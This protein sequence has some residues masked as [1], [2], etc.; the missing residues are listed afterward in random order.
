MLVVLA[1][2]IGWITTIADFKAS[3]EEMP[4]RRAEAKSAIRSIYQMR[5]QDGEWP[6]EVSVIPSGVPN[7]WSYEYYSPEDA[8]GLA[9]FGPYHL[10]L[11]YR[12][13]TAGNREIDGEWWFR[14][15]GSPIALETESDRTP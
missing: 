4:R 13:S 8:P 9:L 15:E 2:V 10:V 1:M 7:G 6:T 3:I 14:C 12:F 5:D 11:R